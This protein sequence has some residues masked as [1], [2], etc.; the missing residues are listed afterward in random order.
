MIGMTEEAGIGIEATTGEE[1]TVVED[2][3]GVTMTGI[4]GSTNGTG[5]GI[6]IGALTEMGGTIDAADASIQ[7]GHHGTIARRRRRRRRNRKPRKQS[8]RQCH[9]GLASR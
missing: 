8:L 9:L 2:T 4:A 5:I 1:T 3:P 6:W 7:T